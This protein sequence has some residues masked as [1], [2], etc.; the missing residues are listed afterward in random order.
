MGADRTNYPLRAVHVIVI[1]EAALLPF[2]EE[3]FQSSPGHLEPK[4]V[5]HPQ[6]PSL[7]SADSLK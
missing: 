5:S 4:S 3:I 6:V 7:T 1:S 2:R